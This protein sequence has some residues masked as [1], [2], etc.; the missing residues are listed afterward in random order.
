MEN[1]IVFD[2]KK[3]FN[4]ITYFNNLCRIEKNN[5]NI[6][7]AQTEYKFR[8]CFPD[9]DF[10]ICTN[11][12][13]LDEYSSNELNNNLNSV[14]SDRDKV[15]KYVKEKFPSHKAIEDRTCYDNIVNHYKTSFHQ[16]RDSFKIKSDD[17]N[18]CKSTKD[19]YDKYLELSPYVVINSRN[20]NKTNGTNHYNRDFWMVINY[21]INNGVRVINTTIAPYGFDF[22]P[23]YKEIECTNDYNEMTAIFQ[24]ANCVYHISDSAGINQNFTVK[25]NMVML[26]N[27]IAFADN[28]DFGDIYTARKD[29]CKSI[30]TDKIFYKKG[31]KSGWDINTA[32]EQILKFAK[33][34]RPKINEFFDDSKVIL[35]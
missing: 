13:P 21:L 6:V 7:Y 32:L 25:C 24:A 17:F 27:G 8:N 31:D 22:G 11:D 30:I 18:W 2:I 35:I 28:D 34:E 4:N 20:T 15:I 16:T 9:A 12:N 3:E 14:N 1:V 5:G 23:L 10:I 29:N 33:S 19:S 26:S